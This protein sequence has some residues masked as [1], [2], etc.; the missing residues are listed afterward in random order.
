MKRL[1]A[2][3][4]MALVSPLLMGIDIYKG[5]QKPH[6]VDHKMFIEVLGVW[7]GEQK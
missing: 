4:V 5:T 1:D 7:C 2:N 3:V 6:P